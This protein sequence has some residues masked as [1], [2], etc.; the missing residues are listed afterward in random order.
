MSQKV[1]IRKMEL[2]DLLEVIRVCNQ[3]F[4]EAAR[5]TSYIA[6]QLLRSLVSQPEAQL[7]AEVEG[8]IAGFLRGKF[9][10]EK[11]EAVIAHIAVHPRYQGRGIGG[12]LV[13]HFEKLA[14][15]RGLRKVSLDTPFARE[16]YEKLGYRCT[17]ITY[18][19]ICDL[20]GKE[21]T[22]PEVRDFKI[23][24]PIRL[25]HITVIA[26]SLTKDDAYRCLSHYFDIYEAPRRI[27]I[28][29]LSGNEVVGI[30]MGKEH[31]WIRD[32][33]AVTY[34]YGLDLRVKVWL[35]RFSVYKASLIGLRY[36][37]I[38][39]DDHSLVKE[40]LREGWEIKSFDTFWTGYTM[41]R[42][43]NP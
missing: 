18:A 20:V 14:K 31:T 42:A 40:L 19:V 5:I 23:V 41:E 29:A 37:G 10:F 34:L 27:S 7:V 28:L 16:F 43:L 4:K 32:L 35:L 30:I 1:S 39:T 17:K 12:K 11:G 15:S 24:D 21:V 6:P 3:A 13:R 36:L 9:D 26:R 33:L 2:E 25:D 22:K 38:R 8:K